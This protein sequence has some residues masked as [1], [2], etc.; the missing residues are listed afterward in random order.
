MKINNPKKQNWPFV[1]LKL[2]KFRDY[3]SNLY[4]LTHMC[5]QTCGCLCVWL[6]LCL[7][8]RGVNV[9]L[10]LSVSEKRRL[11]RTESPTRKTKYETNTCKKIITVNLTKNVCECV[12][13]F[14][15]ES[16]CDVHLCHWVWEIAIHISHTLCLYVS[17]SRF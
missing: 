2:L 17:L 15:V 4:G 14:L 9:Y 13:M 10:S 3:L 7:L 1:H 6:C 8:T 5:T 12:R 16:V 11:N